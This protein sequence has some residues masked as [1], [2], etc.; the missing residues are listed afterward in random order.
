MRGIVIEQL[1]LVVGEAEEPGLLRRP[2]DRR[3]LWRELFA[4]FPVDKLAVIVECLVADRVPTFVTVEIEV[5]GSLQRLPDGDA[6]FVMTWF[7]GA[8]K[9]IIRNIKSRTHSTEICL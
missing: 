5:A 9:C 3:A 8:Y 1:L 6:R 4:P 2:F 7:R